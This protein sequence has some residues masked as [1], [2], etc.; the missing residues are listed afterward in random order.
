VWGAH[1]LREVS[2]AE[3]RRHH[4]RGTTG[5]DQI[6]VNQS[7][8][9]EFNEGLFHRSHGGFELALSPVILALL[10]LWLDRTVGTTPLFCV[11]FAVVAFV[12][13]AVKIF[14]VYRH[15]MAAFEAERADRT[16]DLERAA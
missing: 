16:A 10:G 5:N 13:V 12:G 15:G 4:R 1:R 2:Q 3:L 8:R 14:Y 7:Q 11:L 6:N 9:R